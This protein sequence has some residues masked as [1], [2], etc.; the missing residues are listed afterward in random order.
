MDGPLAGFFQGRIGVA[1]SSGFNFLTLNAVFLIASLPIV[2]LPSAIKAATIA[3]ERWRSD[4]E[5]RVVREF[6]TAFRSS[7]FLGTTLLVGVP[8]ALT[9]VGVVEVHYFVRGGNL[10]AR[11]CFGFVL[12]GLFVMLTSLGYVFVL[13]AREL[14]L[15]TTELWSLCI[16][17]AVQNLFVTGPLFLIEIVGAALLALV[18]PAL[19]LL[20]LPIALLYFMKLT[21]QVGLRR[22]ERRVS[23]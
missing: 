17:L 14:S 20:G 3:L 19:V 5:D 1:L 18:D 22:T 8:L 16:H 12:A 2:T 11:V 15:S 4:G 13:A 23:L 21:A 10:G 6:W 7:S 9:A